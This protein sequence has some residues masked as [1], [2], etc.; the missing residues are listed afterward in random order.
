MSVSITIVQFNNCLATIK[1]AFKNDDK[2]IQ[3]GVLEDVY[4]TPLLQYQINKGKI[5]LNKEY[6][7]L[8]N[9]PDYK[10]NPL[11]LLRTA[12][13]NGKLMFVLKCVNEK[14]LEFRE[15]TLPLGQVGLE[16]YFTYWP[17]TMYKRY[18]DNYDSKIKALHKQTKIS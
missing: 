17:K 9:S 1:A 8:N 2:I 14:N 3:E 4:V 10:L 7:S 16:S 11:K 18:I 15:V 13:A 12:D 6:C 5:I